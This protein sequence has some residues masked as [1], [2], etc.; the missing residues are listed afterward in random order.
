MFCR[1]DGEWY[2]FEAS[3][4]GSLRSEVRRLFAPVPSVDLPAWPRGMSEPPY[5]KKTA[6]TAGREDWILLDCKTIPNPA[7]PSDQIEIC[8]FLTRDDTLVL[9]KQARGSGALS[10]LY[11]QARLAVE[12]LYDSAVARAKFAQCVRTASDGSLSVSRG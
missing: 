7:K 3:Q 12:V 5:N 10:H 9:V 4:L 1:L 8:D 2:E 6:R 11:N